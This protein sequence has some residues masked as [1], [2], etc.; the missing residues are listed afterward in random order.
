MT[1]PATTVA[2]AASRFSSA[3]PLSRCIGWLGQR[4]IEKRKERL[5]NFLLELIAAN[6]ILDGAPLQLITRH[7]LAVAQTVDAGIA[8]F[9][10]EKL[11]S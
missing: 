3:R 6:L 4:F 1:R 5:E 11:R 9:F 8:G 7:A 2:P 10:Q